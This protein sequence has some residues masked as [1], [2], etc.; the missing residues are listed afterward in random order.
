M[1]TNKAEL[2][3]RM[4]HIREAVPDVESLSNRIVERLL[5]EPRFNAGFESSPSA[6][7]FVYV[8]TD[9]EAAT[10]RLIKA[11]LHRGQPVAVPCT[12]SES[13]MIA[14]SI[15]S[16]DELKPGRFGILA[17]EAGGP[18]VEPDLCVL[19]C[20]A[21]TESGDRLGRGG[22]YYDRYLAGHPG[23]TTIALAFDEQVVGAIEAEPHDQRVDYIVT[24]S[25]TIRCG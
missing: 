8:S 16:F 7:W 17:P 18:E 15:D 12:D 5:T 14:R 3:R 13:N 6:V 25:R 10:H 9:N 19:P 24:P 21:V 1:A 2:R 20:V 23:M 11:L 22:G 4:Q